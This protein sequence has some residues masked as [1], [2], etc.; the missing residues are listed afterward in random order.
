MTNTFANEY[1]VLAVL[2]RHPS[3]NTYLG[4][5]VEAIPDDIVACLPP[6]AREQADY[7]DDGVLKRRKA[8]F[9]LLRHHDETLKAYVRRSGPLSFTRFA[10]LALT[11]LRGEVHLSTHN[12]CHLDMKP[13]N[14]LVDSVDPDRPVAILCDFGCARKMPAS[15]RHRCVRRC[16]IIC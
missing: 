9:V 14:V 1:A 5:R 6:F 16:G 12:Y 3:I 8:Q 15:W 4:Q 7:L 2:P 13:D 11:L 10:S